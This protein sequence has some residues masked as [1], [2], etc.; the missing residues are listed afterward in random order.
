[1]R[2]LLLHPSSA[3]VAPK[4][5]RVIHPEFAAA[6]ELPHGLEWHDRA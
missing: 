2:S 4:P 6:E 3:C 1:M 5:R